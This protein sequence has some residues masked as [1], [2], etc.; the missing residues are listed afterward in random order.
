V[1]DAVVWWTAWRTWPAGSSAPCL[2]WA[3]TGAA[4][5]ATV[6][7]A[8]RGLGRRFFMVIAGSRGLAAV[9]SGCASRGPG[10]KRTLVR[11]A[12]G[13]RADRAHDPTGPRAQRRPA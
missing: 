4:R 5:G 12:V 10:H 2:A 3:A 13:R 7:V 11:P 9:R 8:R 6:A 1:F